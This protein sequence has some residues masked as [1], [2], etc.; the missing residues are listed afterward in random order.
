CGTL[1]TYPFLAYEAATKFAV[2]CGRNTVQIRPQNGK[3][4]D[5]EM[6][7]KEISNRVNMTKK[8]DFLLSFTSEPYQITAFRDGRVFIHGSSSIEES[9]KVY[10]QY[11]T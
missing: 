6:L 5:L 1:P 10:Y 7:Q 9:K 3:V 11:F 4:R 2:L 8:N